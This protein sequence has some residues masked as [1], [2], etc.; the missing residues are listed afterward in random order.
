MQADTVVIG[1][2]VVGTSVAFHLAD[3]GVDGVVVLDKGDLDHNDGSTSHAPG[4]LRTLTI[5]PFFTKLGAASRRVYDA[6]PLAVDGEEQFFRTGLMQ[7]ASTQERLESYLRIQERG[8]ALGEAAELLTPDE[9]CGHVPLIDPATIVGGM[10]VPSAGT[11]NTSRIATAMRRVA[12]ATGRARWYRDTEVTEILAENARVT[13]VLTGNPEMPR[14]EC[15]R[16][17]LCSNIWAP[18][19]AGKLGVPMPLFPG[20][21]Q[22][23]FT[24]S[25]A[26]LADRMHVENTMPIVA[27]DDISVYFRQYHDHLGIGSYH[28]PARLVEPSDLG[29]SSERPFTPDDFAE[30]WRLMQYHMP[31]LA[32]ATISRGFNGMFAFTADHYPIMGESA[33][34]A[35]LW[36]A[37]GAWLSFASEVGRVMARWMTEGD[38]GFDVTPA[39][40]NRFHAHQSNHTFLSRQSKYFYE[41]GFDILHPNQVASDVRNLRLSPYHAR[42]EALGAELVPLAGIETPWLYRGNEPLVARYEG[43][44]PPRS[45]YDA[46][47]WSPLIGAEHLAIRDNV[48]LVDWSAAIGPVEVSGPGALGYLQYLCTNDVDRPVGSMVY[49]LVLTPRGTVRRDVTITRLSEDRFWLLTGRSNLP[50]ELAYY[51]SLAPPDGSVTIVDRTEE[52]VAVGLWGPRARQVLERVTTAD[53]DSDAF[54]WYSARPIGVGMAPA[55]AMRISYVGELGWEIYAPVGFGLHLWD[56]LWEAGRHVD[57]TPVGIASVFSLRIEKGYRLT[58]S[59]L[60]PEINPFEAGMGWTLAPDKDFVGRQAAIDARQAGL[61]SQLVTLRFDEPEA[62]M[63]GWEPVLDDDEVVG[64]VAGGEYG[65]TVG[66]FIAHAFVGPSHAEPGTRLTVQ[67]TGRRFAGTVVA[68]PLYDPGN[69]RLKV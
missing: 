55:I 49:T 40:V 46:T 43:R 56:T 12:E 8:M 3:S 58:G 6:L 63:Y 33:L 14:I 35:G 45:G 22:F 36:T 60:T 5:S 50:A 64:R 38:P 10:L 67:Y 59:D 28:H 54:P 65:Y 69:E 48:G 30:A 29:E 27:M 4:G 37:V 34:V 47:A 62:L 66:A 7:V 13:G 68:G 52:H 44:I 26:A 61:A 21:H 51:R 15:E 57:M 42:L 39:D 23:A 2:G 11:V 53:L 24:D 9:V 18:I 41:I 1:A 19:L 16:V 17:V 32:G 25:I 31:S 20:E